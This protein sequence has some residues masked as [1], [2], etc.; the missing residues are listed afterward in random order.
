[1]EDGIIPIDNLTGEINTLSASQIEDI[2]VLIARTLLTANRNEDIYPTDVWNALATEVSRSERIRQKTVGAYTVLYVKD[3]IIL[4]YGRLE[5]D[6][7]EVNGKVLNDVWQLKDLH[8]DPEQQGKGIGKALVNER[9]RIASLRGINNLYL[10]SWIFPPTLGFL[11]ANGY[12][13]IGENPREY[14][15]HQLLTQV[16]EKPMGH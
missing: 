7:L 2:G 13:T 5:R 15:G 3:E 1:M 14:R 16:M 12:R 9:E 4:G 6:D 8:V 10:E 11:A